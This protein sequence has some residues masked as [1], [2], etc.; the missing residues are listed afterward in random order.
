MRYTILQPCP[1]SLLSG[2]MNPW[3]HRLE[4][5]LVRLRRQMRDVEGAC[6]D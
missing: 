3:F 2:L 1:E 4:E 5:A 6:A